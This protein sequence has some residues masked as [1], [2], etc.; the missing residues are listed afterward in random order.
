M[1][2]QLNAAKSF[3]IYERDKELS[4]LDILLNK[5]VCS[6]EIDNHQENINKTI[7][8]LSQAINS[9]QTIDNIIESS[10]SNKS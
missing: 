6:S 8:K 3:W 2:N 9:I 5:S 4:N 7:L 10:N 1:N